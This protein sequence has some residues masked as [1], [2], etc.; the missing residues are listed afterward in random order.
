MKL[1]TLL[2]AAGLVTSVAVAESTPEKAT[3]IKNGKDLLT[4]IRLALRTHDGERLKT[5]QERMDASHVQGYIKG[6][7]EASWV[8]GYA[9]DSVPY[10]LP[11]NITTEQLAQVLLHYLTIHPEKQNKPCYQL[12]AL[13]FTEAFRNPKWK[14]L[15]D[16]PEAPTK[17]VEDD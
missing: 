1:L 12:V 16:A 17:A 4:A 8:L 14:P 11:T 15:P 3:S 5:E 2:L 6:L 7:K 10:I 13:V 9:N